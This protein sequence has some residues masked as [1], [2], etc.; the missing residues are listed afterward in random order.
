MGSSSDRKFVCVC[1]YI[2]GGGVLVRVLSG[3]A[4]Q[5]HE[6]AQQNPEILVWGPATGVRVCEVRTRVS[7]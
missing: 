3:H 1:M 6:R 2:R 7:K 5:V 4:P